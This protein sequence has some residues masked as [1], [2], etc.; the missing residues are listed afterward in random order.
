[1]HSHL[2][3]MNTGITEAPWIRKEGSIQTPMV[4]DLN[5]WRVSE[6]EFVH[7]RSKWSKNYGIS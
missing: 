1:M 5:Q 6:E 7:Q 3:A 2:F 4:V